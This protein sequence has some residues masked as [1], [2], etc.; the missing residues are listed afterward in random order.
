MSTFRDTAEYVRNLSE[1]EYILLK[2]L[3]RYSKRF[4]RVSLRLL[5]KVTKFS[6]EYLMAI[7]KR[8]S[9]EGFVIYFEQ[10]YESVMLLTSG[11]DLLALK[12][13]SDKGVVAGVGRQIGVGK[14]SDV[15]DAIDPSGTRITLKVFRLGRISFKDVSRKRSYASIKLSHK[16]IWRNYASAKREYSNLSMLYQRGVSVP[17]PIYQLMHILVMEAL[18][19][20]L[21]HDLRE[22]EQPY[23][24][25]RSIMYE[26]K[27]TWDIGFV[28]GD[29]SE[30]N[31]FLQWDSLKPIL[32]DW[33]QAFSRNDS[34]AVD[35]L[36]RDVQ[37]VINFF[38]KKHECDSEKLKNI[39][40]ELSLSL[41]LE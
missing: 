37:N 28:N 22:V 34:N 17:R 12:R 1:G 15:Y 24:L 33:P 11:L 36:R 41:V 23:I 32:I 8:L 9:K 5:K 35:L 26:V 4:E 27:K 6:D 38:V 10:P 31:I 7:I 2:Y 25:F 21:L 13:L 3:E 16:W 19:G 39:V 40:K 20:I 14:E 30:Y 18:D 29:L